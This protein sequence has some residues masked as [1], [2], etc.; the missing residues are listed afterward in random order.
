MKITCNQF[1]NLLS[2]YVNNELTDNL[3]Q[4]FEDHLN[5][6][7]QC[8]EKYSIIHSII[9]E[10]KEAY[11]KFI[12]S[13]DYRITK[14]VEE[15]C[16][17]TDCNLL[18]LS[19][20]VDN[21][22]PEERSVKIR[23]SIVSRPNVRKKVEKLYKLRKILTESFIDEKNSLKSDFSRSIVRSLNENYEYRRAYIHCLIF[24][25]VIVAS[26]VLSVWFIFHVV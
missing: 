22:L 15:D 24:I 21:E 11:N 26:V 2:F 20:Y 3:K 23:Q 4:A 10:I 7:P 12:N 17:K 13:E 6:C 25:M 1:E 8:R 19:A 14:T 16:V 5:I 18:E 9:D